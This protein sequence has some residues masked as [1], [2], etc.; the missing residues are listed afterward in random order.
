MKKN[1]NKLNSATNHHQTNIVEYFISSVIKFDKSIHPMDL[2]ETYL[3]CIFLIINKNEKNEGK[4]IE[5]KN[6]GVPIKY[7]YLSSNSIYNTKLAIKLIS[8]H[9]TFT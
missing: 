9:S 3:I 7:S 2:Y 6:E 5:L 1:I 8:R 4:T